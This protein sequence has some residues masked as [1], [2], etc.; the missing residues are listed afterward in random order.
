VWLY[1]RFSLS[2]REVEDL[3][4]ERGIQVSY[5]TIRQW[6]TKFGPDYAAKLKR[7]CGRL[8]DIWRLDEVFISIRGQRHYLWRAVDQG[9]DVL[10]ILVQRRRDG[11][12]A[13][14][15]FRK[16]LKGQGSEPCRLITDKLRSYGLAHRVVMPSVVHDTTQ[17]ANNRAELSHEPTRQRERQMRRFKSEAQAQRFLA[18]HGMVGNL[19][20]VGRHLLRAANHRMLRSRA[21][22]EWNAVTCA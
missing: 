7:R 16:L 10:D 17:Y 12:A 18:V 9:G 6:C 2:F 22:V 11:R 5:E 8:G 15:F 13:K 1:H 20:R 3:F 4:A 19:F 14:L 21:F